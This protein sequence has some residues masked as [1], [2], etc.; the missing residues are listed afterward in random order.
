VNHSASFTYLGVGFD[1]ANGSS[2]F[3]AANDGS[4]TVAAKSVIIVGGT[5]QE[6]RGFW[7]EFSPDDA[8]ALAQGIIDAA[9]HAKG[10]V[11]S[12]AS[13]T[14]EDLLAHILA[15]TGATE[16]DSWH[17]EEDGTWR[18]SFVAGEWSLATE[19]SKHCPCCTEVSITVVGVQD[20][21]GDIGAGIGRRWQRVECS[22]GKG[23]R[24]DAQQRSRRVRGHRAEE[25][26]EPAK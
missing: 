24:G 13:W 20:S 2:G 18:R 23:T 5:G 11:V 25:H 8:I 26:P 6:R 4:G 1:T 22:R 17:E 10:G 12:A 14:P 16:V 19:S 21:S 7:L 9:E 15:P 3:I